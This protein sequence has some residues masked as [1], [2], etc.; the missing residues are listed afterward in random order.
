M[1]SVTSN[2]GNETFR[3]LAALLEAGDLEQFSRVV[4]SL[5]AR[6]N[7]A[8]LDGLLQAVR[9]ISSACAELNHV[10]SMHRKSYLEIRRQQ[11][12]MLGKLESLVGQLREEPDSPSPGIVDSAPP[13]GKGR[14]RGSDASS[15]SRGEEWGR[16]PQLAIYYLSPFQV[17][18][19]DVPLQGWSNGKGK[20]IFK[21]LGTIRGRAVAKEMLMEMFWPGAAP[22]SARNNLNVAICGLRR[23][24][25]R[26]NPDYS[27]VLYRNGSYL[28]N[29]ELLVWTD[30]EEFLDRFRAGRRHEAAGDREAACREYRLAEALYQQEFLLEDR[31]ED[32]AEEM[33]VELRNCH[34]ST[35]D[36]LSSF[37]FDRHDY[38]SCIAVCRK[39]LL[40]DPCFE[41]FHRLMM[42]CY[43]REGHT[44]L[45]LRQ[46]HYCREALMRELNAAPGAATRQLHEQIRLGR[47]V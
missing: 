44:H 41:H 16:R 22:Q 19:D 14:L 18:L 21:Y 34:I 37:H 24:L 45:A 1:G 5:L 32:W 10:L 35:L 43:Y 40:T 6:G 31:Y 38:E 17:Y 47:E 4:T 8:A 12:E 33:R 11:K 27:Y 39:A 3:Q 13:Q 29:P 26:A 46:Y 36:R 42:R 7:G 28:L 9:N 30:F 23:T 15:S 20:M 2:S 25:A